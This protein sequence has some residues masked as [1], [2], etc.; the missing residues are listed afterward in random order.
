MI[1]NNHKYQ[2]FLIEKDKH[3]LLFLIQ[4]TSSLKS[5]SVKFSRYSSFPC[6]FIGWDTRGKQ[7]NPLWFVRLT[8]C[9]SFKAKWISIISCQEISL[10]YPPYEIHLCQKWSFN[11]QANLQECGGPHGVGEEKLTVQSIINY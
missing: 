10:A 2:K 11:L 9:Q 4:E 1:R 5:W 6:Q 7:N 3:A 8:G